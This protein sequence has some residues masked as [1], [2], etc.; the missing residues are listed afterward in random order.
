M[1]DAV[2]A[3]LPAL[4]VAASLA[5]A[6]SHAARNRVRVQ[7]RRAGSRA[8]FEAAGVTDIREQ[9]NPQY[10]GRL[11]GRRNGA[12]V[13]IGLPGPQGTETAD[14]VIGLR[15]WQASDWL[16]IESRKGQRPGPLEIEVG[17]PS[18]D[19]AVSVSG[20]APAVLALLDAP[21][22]ALVAGLL[23]GEVT[24]S[25]GAALP[26]RGKAAAGTGEA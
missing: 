2:L 12:A 3:A 1:L 14:L 5:V 21:T 23:R 20:S 7:A 15:G 25:T 6:W 22:R 4:F 16:S 26:P 17:D 8:A 9:G 24:A 11:V 19:S 13:S 10:G 18:F